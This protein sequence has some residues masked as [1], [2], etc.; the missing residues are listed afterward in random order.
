LILG[1]SAY[2]AAKPPRR[3]SDIPGM[4]DIQ[5]RPLVQNGIY[6]NKKYGFSIAIPEGFKVTENNPDEDTFVVL[7]ETDKPEEKRSFQIFVMPFDEPG[8][9]N[10]ERILIDLPDAVVDD[11]REITLAGVP[12]LVFWGSDESL[13]KTRE[14]W[15]IHSG[16]MFQISSY[17]SFDE[18]LSKI[19]ATFKFQ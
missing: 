13:G 1:V 16:S 6:Q 12:A 15:F 2:L 3:M 10:K 8:P 14:V 7:V 18:E 5:K 9:V 11:P 17:A 19:M 4:S